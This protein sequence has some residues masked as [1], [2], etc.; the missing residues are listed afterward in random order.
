MADSSAEKKPAG[1]R[2]RSGLSYVKR[3]WREAPPGRYVPFR[4][5]GA[6]IAAVGGDEFARQGWDAFGGFGSQVI[7]MMIYGLPLQYFAVVGLITL[8][9][10]YLWSF[11]GWIVQ[12]NLGHLSRSLTKL[13]NLI[14]VP[15]FL[16]GLGL[17]IF[18]PVSAQESIM[19]GF[20]KIIGTNLVLSVW[21]NWRGIFWRRLLLEKLGRYKLWPYVNLVPR[22]FWLLVLLWLPFNNLVTAERFWILQF[23]FNCYGMYDMKNAAN[24]VVSVISPDQYERVDIQ[25]YPGTIANAL[26]SIPGFLMPM[27]GQFLHVQTETLGYYR[28]VVF[29]VILV[30]LLMMF[31]GLGKIKERIPAPP[32]KYK[33]HIN[34]WTG[35]DAVMR[36]KYKWMQTVSTLVDSLASN[37]LTIN[38]FLIYYILRQ[39]GAFVGIFNTIVVT[40]V[41]PGVLIAPI[42]MR[43]IEYRKLYFINRTLSIVAQFSAYIALAAGIKDG[44][45]FAFIVIAAGWFARLFGQVMIQ[46]NGVM[47]TNLNDYQMWCSGERMESFTGIFSWLTAP[48]LTLMGFMIPLMYRE[49]GYTGNTDVLFMDDVRMKVMMAGCVIAVIGDVA[50]LIPMLWFKFSAKQQR[51]IT[52]DLEWRVEAA[53]ALDLVNDAALAEENAEQVLRDVIYERALNDAD[54]NGGE[55]P[56]PPAS[57]VPR[58][59]YKGGN[60]AIPQGR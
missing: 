47:E 12:D 34:F 26:N 27:I 56:A 24:K 14:Y 54:E 31:A 53:K 50:S 19:P 2:I 40:A 21:G 28:Y 6:S 32:M 18:V 48:I 3:Y 20:W 11:F 5:W 49:H 4:E 22:L 43:K 10:G 41:T 42:L 52:K 44:A 30:G 33:P 17:L 25:A 35:T 57:Y 39:T 8:P 59:I 36:N 23:C 51:Q 55:P 29:V 60:S 16:V 13:I 46:V 7:C 37:A 1:E 9:M 38:F 58:G 15:L 45:V